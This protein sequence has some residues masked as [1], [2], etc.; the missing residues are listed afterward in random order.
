MCRG[1]SEQ[2]VCILRDHCLRFTAAPGEWPSYFVMPGGSILGPCIDFID[3]N[4]SPRQKYA[5]VSAEKED[6]RCSL[7]D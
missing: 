1:G 3:N 5:K 4:H 7:Q 6:A 2:A